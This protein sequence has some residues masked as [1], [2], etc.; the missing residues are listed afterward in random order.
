M[1]IS[2]ASGLDDVRA[3][4]AAGAK[5]SGRDPAAVTLLAASKMQEA[6]AIAKLISKGQKTFGENR[7][8]EAMEKWPDIRK[9]FPDVRLHMIG[10]LQS[11]KVRDAV[12]LFDII[13]TLDRES[14]AD[15][16]A[17][18]MERQ[19]RR[20]P[21]LIQVNTG[22]EP[23][24]GGVEPDK[25]PA[26]LGHCRALKL[27]ITGLMCIPP[28]HEPSALH[29]ALLADM[30]KKLALPQ[31]SMGMSG[32]FETAIRFGATTVRI[33]TALFGERS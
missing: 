4:I 3:R 33:G 12:A 24:K 19:G 32:D 20:I 22:D 17:R 11:N 23:Q 30:A 31:L 26:L 7:V 28:T 13:E 18:E 16:L 6:G 27:E 5:A 21:C 8:Q 25:A 14:L 1:N 9:T 29:F 10:H 2:A 15:E